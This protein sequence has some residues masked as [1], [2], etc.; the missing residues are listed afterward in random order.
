M[1]KKSLDMEEFEGGG[2]EYEGVVEEMEVES[3]NPMMS[4]T[5]D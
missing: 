1:E 4:L 5:E 2:A 3:N